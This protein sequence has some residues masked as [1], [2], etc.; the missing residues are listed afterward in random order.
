MKVTTSDLTTVSN[1]AYI[2]LSGGDNGAATLKS[3]LNGTFLGAAFNTAI[4]RLSSSNL[5]VGGNATG[6]I[7]V[8]P[9]NSDLV[10]WVTLDELRS[11]VGCQGAPLKLVNNE[12]PYGSASSSTYS[13]MIIADGGVPSTAPDSYS[14][15]IQTTALNT[16]PA[17]LIFQKPDASGTS[18]PIPPNLYQ[19]NCPNYAAASW[20]KAGKLVLSGTPNP[21]GSYFITVY[22]S[23]T[24]SNIASKPFVLTINP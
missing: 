19:T 24:N 5:A 9:T 16:A 17:A 21:P 7:T 8:D 1:V 12:L 2:I 4:L 23:D 15:C 18:I 6:T 10:R 3:T 22:V 14:W 11:K 13:A 20:P